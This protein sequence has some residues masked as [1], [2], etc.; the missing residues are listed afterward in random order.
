MFEKDGIAIIENFLSQGNLENINTELNTIFSKYTV[1]GGI[2]S[3]RLNRGY[4]P[5]VSGCTIPGLIYS[6][7]IFELV[8]D[9][10]E[11]FKKKFKRFTSE[12]YVLTTLEIFHEKENPDPLFWHTDNRVG[13]LRAII[14]LKGGGDNSGKFMYMKGTHN[15]DYFVRHQLSEQQISDLQDKRFECTAPEG[16]LI[17]FDSMGFHAK[18]ECSEERRI[19]FVEFQPRDNQSFKERVLLPSNHLSEKVI[20]HINLFANT[21][22]KAE[23]IGRHSHEFDMNNPVPLPFRTSLVELKR[24]VF[25]DLL[26]V[27]AKIWKS[28]PSLKNFKPK[29]RKFF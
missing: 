4:I 9:V 13:N 20:H 29:L 22:F 27:L 7:N 15:R 19:M 23:D 10:A 25:Y 21:D 24:S 14:Y 2:S 8:V 1:N 16:S 6:V 26:C 12:D 17:I 28:I 18:K 11:Q 5:K 3:T